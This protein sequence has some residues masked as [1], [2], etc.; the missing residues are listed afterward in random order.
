M[1]AMVLAVYMPPQ[2][3]SPG[4]MAFSM[5]VQVLEAHLAGG[6]GADGFE[7]VDEG[8]FLFGA[9]LELDP[10]G[11]DGAGVEEDGG[12][13][14]AGGGHQHAGQRL[15]AAGQQHGAV[16][17]LGLHDGLD[18]VGDDFA[19][20]QGE[21]HALVAHGDAVRDGDGAELH[22]E[23][24]AGVD[25]FLGA[26]GEPVQGE[27]AGGDLVPRAR[28][29]DLRLGEVVV[30]HAD[31]PEHAARGG[32]VDSVGNDP[33]AGLDVRFGVCRCLGVLTHGSKSRALPQGANDPRTEH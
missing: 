33:A 6:A 17:P 25:A 26:L 2:A 15:V 32:G 8:D 22:G 28:H 11:H 14:Q 5:R 16:D 30:A 27:V 19:G 23:P 18:G 13:V 4:Q 7:R 10:A 1:Q 3:P 29:A 12:E 31:R 24:A 21:V 20:H 9:V